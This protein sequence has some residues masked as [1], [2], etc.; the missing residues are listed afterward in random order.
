[1]RLHNLIPCSAELTIHKSS[2]LPYLTYC[3]LVWRFFKASESRK[4]ERRQERASRAVYRAYS[5]C[6]QTLLKIS[7]LP[8]LQ[9]RRL[10]DIATLMYKFKNNFAP[11]NVAEL[12]I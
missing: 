7:G 9:N 12:F 4:M 3:H 2:I 11:T 8:T 10:Q 5:A 1:M 6:Y